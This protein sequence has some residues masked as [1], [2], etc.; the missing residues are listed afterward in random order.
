MFG[1]KSNNGRWRVAALIALSLIASARARSQES[2]IV[3][4]RTPFAWPTSPAAASA[5]NGWSNPVV[6][7]F[8]HDV[9]T[10][11]RGYF[12]PPGTPQVRVYDFRFAPLERGRFYLVLV[13]GTR[14]DQIYTLGPRADGILLTDMQTVVMGNLSLAMALPDLKGNGVHELVTA[15]LP[16]SFPIASPPLI[17]WYTVWQFHNGVPKD[18]SAKFPSFYRGFVLP[19]LEYPEQLLQRVKAIGAP[20]TQVPLAA[21]AYVRF[22]YERDVLGRPD[23]GL[24][25]ALAWAASKNSDLFDIGVNSLA[26]MTAPAA[27][28]ELEKLAQIP[29]N[30]D[31]LGLLI[32]RRAQLMMK[33]QRGGSK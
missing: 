14:W 32:A 5:A 20:G 16:A 26:D 17:Y 10:H 18:A 22:K 25:E 7:D 23:A 33:V 24:K 12:R 15:T 28:A 21:I 31:L 30:R 13:A 4:V 6:A 11:E 9:V 27:G 3:R 8:F 19:Q 2:Q 1:A 29:V